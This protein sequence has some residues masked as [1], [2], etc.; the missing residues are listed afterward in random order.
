LTR[1]DDALGAFQILVRQLT[2][3]VPLLNS[4]SRASHRCH[5]YSLPGRRFTA[6]GASRSTVRSTV[7]E[8]DFCPSV[9]G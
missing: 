3:G 9:S 4:S 1:C 6:L 7:A 8:H 5:Q 2:S